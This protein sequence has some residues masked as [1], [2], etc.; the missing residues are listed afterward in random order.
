MQKRKVCF[1]FVALLS[2]SACGGSSSNG[3]DTFFGGS[4]EGTVFRQ[5][6]SCPFNEDVDSYLA[7]HLVNQD[8]ERVVLDISTRPQS[9]EGTTQEQGFFVSLDSTNEQIFDD[10]FCNRSMSI[11]YSDANRNSA[12]VEIVDNVDCEAS[13]TPFR[14]ESVY[15]GEVQREQQ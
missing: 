6:N 7:S 10:V 5:S 1:L 9:F 13:S 11:E 12:S 8:G 2:V 14:C 15:V 3:S 4:W